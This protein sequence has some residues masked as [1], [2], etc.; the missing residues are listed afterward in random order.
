MKQAQFEEIIEAQLQMIRGTLLA[1]QKEYA[2]EDRLHNFKTVAGLRD[3]T[4]EQALGGMLAKHTV[5]IYDMIESGRKYSSTQWDEKIND[6]IIYLLLLKAIVVEGQSHTNVEI[7][8][9]EL[10]AISKAAYGGH[11]FNSTPSETGTKYIVK[12]GEIV[13]E[14]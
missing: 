1:K 10:D 14:E 11:A 8:K 6:H 4:M 2:T 3:C 12:D 5:S 7:I 9:K 13:V